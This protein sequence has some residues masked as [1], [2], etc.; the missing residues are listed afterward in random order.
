MDEKV[1]KN[2]HKAMRRVEKR[3]P[4]KKNYYAVI[5]AT[6]EDN[7]FEII[8]TRQLFFRRYK[9]IDM[10]VVGLSA[11]YDGAVGLMEQMIFDCMDKDDDLN[12]RKFFEDAK[13][14]KRKKSKRHKRKFFSKKKKD[15]VAKM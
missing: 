8:G 6:N 2:P 12:V 9:N 11:D 3:K 14:R 5:L 4:W 13:F 10:K 15:F 7:L 1:K